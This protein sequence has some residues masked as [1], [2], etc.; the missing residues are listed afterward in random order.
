MTSTNMG[1]SAP[2]G[3]PPR[4][5]RAR[6][7]ASLGASLL[8]LLCRDASADQ[9][10]LTR[11]SL[12]DAIRL[13]LEHNPDSRSADQDVVGAQGAVAQAR[14]LPN[15]SVFISSLDTGIS[16]A[17]APVPNQYGFIW[18]IPFGGKRAAGIRGAEAD[19]RAAAAGRQSR[20]REL[21]FDVET[22]FVHLQLD[23]SLLAF[24][25][26]DATAFNQLLAINEIRFEDGKISYG[27]VLKLRIQ[28]RQV[29]DTVRQAKQQVDLDRIELAR[30]VGGGVL[31]ADFEVDGVLAPPA[32]DRDVSVRGVTEAAI[33]NRPEYQALRAQIDSSD[34]ARTLARRQSIPDIGILAD[35]NRIPDTAGTYDL[36]L[37]VDVPIF[38]QNGG[39]IT[40]ADAAYEKSRLSLA[41]LNNQLTAD[42]ARVVEQR[43]VA[44][45]RLAAYSGEFVK[46]A[47]ESLDISVHSY[48]EGRGTLLEVVDAESSY[49]DV[50]RAYR[51]A[52]ADVV[53]AAA[54]VKYVA[55]EALP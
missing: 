28:A 3:P 27:D 16:P 46:M 5:L 21:A 45:Q 25:Q 10:A 52:Q 31:A 42:A 1:A 13:A 33:R 29:E 38:N 15:P 39:A 11:V 37:T 23:Q 35:Y 7:A 32:T 17:D 49:R 50:E 40:Q 12:P 53:L 48:T 43:R 4:R 34:A 47:K 51:S 20:R 24:T 18:A 36:Q 6:L 9:P 22:A 8:C 41:S 55:G 2:S 54:A 19:K 26:Q 14:A 44:E 30:L